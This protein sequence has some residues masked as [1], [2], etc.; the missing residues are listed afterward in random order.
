MHIIVTSNYDRLKGLLKDYIFTYIITFD[1]TV[2]QNEELKVWLKKNGLSN[3]VYIYN[4]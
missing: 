3:R 2:P 4:L 1:C